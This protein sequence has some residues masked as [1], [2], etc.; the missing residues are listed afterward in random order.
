MKL[1]SGIQES[2]GKYFTNMLD[3]IN[4]VQLSSESKRGGKLRQIRKKMNYFKAQKD[5]HIEG[6]VFCKEDSVCIYQLFK[7]RV[8]CHSLK[9][10]PLVFLCVNHFPLNSS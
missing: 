7:K 2:N 1:A 8:H 9:I 5:S 3:L 6:D 10:L 4:Q